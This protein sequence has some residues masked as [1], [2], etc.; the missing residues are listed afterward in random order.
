MSDSPPSLVDWV[1]VLDHI[2]RSLANSLSL[3]AEPP[4]ETPL[5]GDRTTGPLERLDA[6]LALWQACLERV[7]AEAAEAEALVAEQE[8][9][10]ADWHQRQ[11]AARE[12]LE[13]SAECR[14]QSA[15]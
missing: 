15:E 6:K 3:A 2:E 12:R 13:R 10:L 9:S 5:A 11:Q 1:G 7:Q 8:Q 14:V 4:A